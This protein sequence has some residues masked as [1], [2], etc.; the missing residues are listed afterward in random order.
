MTVGNATSLAGLAVY[1]PV[2]VKGALTVGGLL[3]SAL[4]I[5]VSGPLIYSGSGAPTIAPAVQ[6]S[7]YLRSDGSA[8]N[9][10]LYVCTGTT[11][12]TWIA[13]QTPS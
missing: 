11:S 8:T 10:R 5:A 1:G 9:N 6:G 7:L 13:I 3:T 2:V 4:Q 12:G